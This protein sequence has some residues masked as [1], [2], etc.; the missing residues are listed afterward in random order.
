MKGG[1]LLLR[2]IAVISSSVATIIST[3][4]PLFLYVSTPNIELISIF[5][6]LIF[7]A[8]LIHGV[9]THALNDY[10]DHLSGTD[11]NSPAILSGGSRVI[12]TEVF[13]VES[14]GRFGKWLSILL[15]MIL[16]VFLMLGYYR[17]AVLLFVG[18]WAAVA[19]SVPPLRFS[20]RPFIGEWLCTFPSVLFLGFAGAW[21]ALGS[22]PEWALQNAVINALICI[23]WVMVHH[24]PDLD[25][26]K[27]AVP[28]KR[29]SVVWAAE[30]FGLAW[31]R[32]PALTYYFL[33]FTCT[34]WLIP[35]RFWA[36][37]GVT[38]VTAVSALFI[39]K[40]NVADP[41]QVSS[42]EK[43]MLMLAILNAVWLG[44]FI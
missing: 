24:I 6:L 16:L 22:P 29:T 32:L 12:Q 37:A 4:L 17:L 30:K 9:L 20:Y 34:A 21:L 28:P 19:Y 18:L 42:Y 14:L 44:I 41:V 7:S 35:E 40:M 39:F 31:S 43:I 36:G 5:I 38:I 15:V 25:A 2:S 1:I 26:D 10:T 8:F 13:S 33:A 11:T 3:M 23:A 27:N